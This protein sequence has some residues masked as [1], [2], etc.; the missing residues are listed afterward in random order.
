MMNRVARA[1][2]NRSNQLG[3]SHESWLALISYFAIVLLAVMNFRVI[4]EDLLNARIQD[5]ISAAAAIWLC[6]NLLIITPLLALGNRWIAKARIAKANKKAAR[7]LIN[8]GNLL[9]LHD[10]PAAM[11]TYARAVELD[12]NN[13]EGWNQLGH[14]QRRL[15]MFDAAEQ[16]YRRVLGLGNHLQ[17]K[18]WEAY[19]AVNLGSLYKEQNDMAGAYMYWTK[20][21][22]LYREIGMEPQ[23]EQVENWLSKAE[24]GRESTSSSTPKNRIKRG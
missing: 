22:R 1:L 3:H 2:I 19:G 10:T 15:R 13:P 4:D 17:D 11:R 18:K 9:N 5:T 16:S 6:I 7:A 24:Q 8:K 20:A 23:I 14:M 21:L 12:A